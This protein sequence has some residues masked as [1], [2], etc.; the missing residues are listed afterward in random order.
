[1]TK[2][3]DVWMAMDPETSRVLIQDREF[4]IYDFPPGLRGLNWETRTAKIDEST[5][6]N[7]LAGK[8]S[9]DHVDL[10]H[11]LLWT[12]NGE[13]HWPGYDIIREEVQHGSN[14]I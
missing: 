4:Q 13:D 9:N 8:L 3:I 2:K 7:I 10:I 6:E 5:Y 14:T 1:M 12:E 11:R